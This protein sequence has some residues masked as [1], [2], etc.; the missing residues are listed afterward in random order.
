MRFVNSASDYFVRDE[1]LFND[2]TICNL[3][4]K[5]LIIFLISYAESIRLLS[6]KLRI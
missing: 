5:T 6:I 1:Y 4:Y 3:E 2:S